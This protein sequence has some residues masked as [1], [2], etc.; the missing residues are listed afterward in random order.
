[1]TAEPYTTKQKPVWRLV[2]SQEPI[3]QFHMAASVMKSPYPGKVLDGIRT[4][5]N[6]QGASVTRRREKSALAW[7]VWSD[8]M[9]ASSNSLQ[10]S[11]PCWTKNRPECLSCE[12]G[13]NFFPYQMPPIESKQP[14]HPCLTSGN[15]SCSSPPYFGSGVLIMYLWYGTHRKRRETVE[16]GRSFRSSGKNLEFHMCRA[17]ALRL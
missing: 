3:H 13:N 12:R 7:Y 9:R 6:D 1:M 4:L 14:P 8:H 16:Q 15:G 17:H 11:E 10:V 5:G 2:T